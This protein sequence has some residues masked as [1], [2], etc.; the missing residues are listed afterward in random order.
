MRKSKNLDASVVPKNYP[1]IAKI[2]TKEWFE[3]E[4]RKEKEEMHLL[5]RQFTYGEEDR[6]SLHLKNMGF[7][8]QLEPPIPDSKKNGSGDIQI[9]DAETEVF[10]EVRT[11]RGK[12][13]EI[14]NKGKWVETRRM[15]FHRS[16]DFGYVIENES[17][18][19]SD[20]KVY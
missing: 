10:I 6:I 5:A 19:Y 15:E 11:I 1:N 14:V 13:G 2:F 20:A 4:F 7:L 16:S 18:Q 3:S 9:I 8:V 17:Y 12:K